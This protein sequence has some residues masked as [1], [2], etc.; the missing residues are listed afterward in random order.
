MTD[1]ELVANFLDLTEK[2]VEA[3][4]FEKFEGIVNYIK[5]HLAKETPFNPIFHLNGKDY[6]FIPNLNDIT[7]GEFT[8][9]SKIGVEKENLHKLMSI[10][11]RPIT[12]KLGDKYEIE[13]YNGQS[14]DVM[15]DA[16]MD[17]VSG[18]LFFFSSLAT[19]LENSILSYTVES[20]QKAK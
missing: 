18:A 4:E 12:N 3:I 5:F 1:V 15:L 7:F 2:Q 6:G 14:A 19:E 17:A 16:P 13:P 20:R 11:F 10:L 8:A 9:L